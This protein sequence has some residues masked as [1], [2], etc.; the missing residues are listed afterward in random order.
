MWGF[1]IYNIEVK[2]ESSISTD[3][4]LSGIKA[5]SQPPASP[6]SPNTSSRF[7]VLKCRHMA[8]F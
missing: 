4:V 2:N 1:K 6:R 3:L 8:S 7:Q 5:D